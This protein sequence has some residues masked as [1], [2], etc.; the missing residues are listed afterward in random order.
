MNVLRNALAL[1]ATA[2]LAGS[3]HAAVVASWAGFEAISSND[4]IVNP[5]SVLQAINLGNEGGNVNVTTTAGTIVFTPGGFG[6]SGFGND[7]FFNDNNTDDGGATVTGDTDSDFHQVL[8]TFRD[9]G[10]SGVTFT[11]LADG[12]YQ[13]QVFVSDDRGNRTSRLLIMTDPGGL[14]EAVHADT[15]DFS[16]NGSVFRSAYNIATVE[17]TGGEGGFTVIDE[18]GGARPVNAVVLTLVPEPGSLALLGLGGLLIAR[19]R[20][21]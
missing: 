7:G 14:G 20:R 13:V 9:N 16:V 21:A 18:G 4:D 12:I 8:D 17:L 1:T 15:G 19:R 5:G 6:G 3:A 2:T 10:N 11:G